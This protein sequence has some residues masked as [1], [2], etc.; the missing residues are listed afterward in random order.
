MYKCSMILLAVCG[1]IVLGGSCAL[2]GTLTGYD[3]APAG[4]A[5]ANVIQ[6]SP[7]CLND[8]TYLTQLDATSYA[9][10]TWTS[11]QTFNAVDL[12]QTLDYQVQGFDLQVAKQGVTNPNLAIDSDWYTPTGWSFTGSTNDNTLVSGSNITSYGVRVKGTNF[13]SPS[14]LNDHLRLKELMVLQNYS[15]NASLTA[16]VGGTAGWAAP[17]FITDGSFGTQGF[18]DTLTP[19]PLTFT[20]AQ[21]QTIGAVVVQGGYGG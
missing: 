21:P 8:L 9:G 4:T 15:G 14:G 10:I 3:I 18:I 5:G 11:A 2:A 7:T 12:Q 1:L 13:Q 17:S 20:S 16:T 19:A 6:G